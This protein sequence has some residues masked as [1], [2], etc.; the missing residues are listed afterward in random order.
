LEEAVAA[1][2]E[3]MVERFSELEIKGGRRPD[4]SPVWTKDLWPAPLTVDEVIAAIRGWDREEHEVDDETYRIYEKIAD[5]K[6][7]PAKAWL[8]SSMQRRIEGEYE[9][10]EW[11]IDLIAMTGKN[12]GYGF[13]IREEKL[14]R[15]PALLPGPGYAWIVEPRD[16]T[17]VRGVTHHAGNGAVLFADKEEDGALVVTA[18]WLQREDARGFRLVAFDEKANRHILDPGI[19]AGSGELAMR[20]FR[21]EPGELPANR[22]QHVGFEAVSS[23]NLRRV[24]EAAVRRAEEEGIEILPWPQVGQPYE[25]TLTT[26]DG[27]VIDPRNSRGKVLLIDCWASWCGPCMKKMPELKEIYGK[28]HGRGLEVIC[29]SF[30]Q[31]VEAAKAAFEAHEIPWPMVFVPNDKDVRQLWIEAVRVP[32]IP[33]VLL[34][35][36]RGV[37]HADLTGLSEISELGKTIAA[38]F[39]R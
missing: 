25:F 3:R 5:S 37:L 10:K 4:G 6:A 20:R 35:G 19:F 31:D 12:K 34:I 33:R 21:L 1:L 11:W 18:A 39:A 24:S 16:V 32:P 36:Q 22:V 17:P 2:N 23:K 27:Q 28:W 7:L 14:T 29:L 15:R 9:N 30:D 38:L 13:R 8:E 26:T